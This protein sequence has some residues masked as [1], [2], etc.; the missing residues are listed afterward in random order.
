MKDWSR[1]VYC[2]KDWDM[3]SII[4]PKLHIFI[5]INIFIIHKGKGGLWH[6]KNALHLQIVNI[7]TFFYEIIHYIVNSV[8]IL[9]NM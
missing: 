1:I 8:N 2:T 6:I 3:D 9:Y 5:I 7:G 4:D